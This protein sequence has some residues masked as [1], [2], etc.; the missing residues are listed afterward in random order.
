MQL[1]DAEKNTIG[2][3]EKGGTDIFAS[4][5]ILSGPIQKSIACSL[6]NLRKY[7]SRFGKVCRLRMSI[8][9]LQM[10]FENRSNRLQDT[11]LV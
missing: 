1:R 11:V 7:K 4:A 6:E 2:I 3:V 8:E 9:R 5:T 10:Y